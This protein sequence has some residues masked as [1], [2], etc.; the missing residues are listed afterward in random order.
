MASNVKDNTV[1]VRLLSEIPYQI[2]VVRGPE[3]KRSVYKQ[4]QAEFRLDR[5]RC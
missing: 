4:I 5:E 1:E 2:P 3:W